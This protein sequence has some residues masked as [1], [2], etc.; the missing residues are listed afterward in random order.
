MLN[1]GYGKETTGQTA[2]EREAQGEGA[3]S[4]QGAASGLESPAIPKG[5]GKFVGV[6]ISVVLGIAAIAA[7][8]I[9]L[10]KVEFLRGDQ[11]PWKTMDKRMVVDEAKSK[12]V[13]STMRFY[14]YRPG[15]VKRWVAGVE[16]QNVRSRDLD[17]ILG[18]AVRYLSVLDAAPN[19]RGCLRC[20]ARTTGIDSALRK[21][22]ARCDGQGRSG[23]A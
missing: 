4:E 13:G 3:Q 7:G 16:D 21:A 11:T 5:T 18:R 23:I 17:F 20:S 9:Y 10:P 19:R 15:E 8:F 2:F 22:G 6:A 1:S 14:K 12:M